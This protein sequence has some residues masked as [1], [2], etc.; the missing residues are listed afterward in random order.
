MGRQAG[1]T[2]LGLS[3]R[4]RRRATKPA[5][6]LTHKSAWDSRE[7]TNA[8][9][10]NEPGRSV[11][12]SGSLAP[13]A[14]DHAAGWHRRAAAGDNSPRQSQLINLAAIVFGGAGA[15]A[16]ATERKHHLHGWRAASRPLLGALFPA[17]VQ[18]SANRSPRRASS[19]QWRPCHTCAA[20]RLNGDATQ[21]SAPTQRVATRNLA[22]ERKRTA[23]SCS[24]EPR[25]WA[26]FV[27]PADC[28]PPGSPF[29]GWRRHD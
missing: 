12:C 28:R 27:A 24:N 22:P 20:R 11:V 1:D 9:G 29:V 2:S 8:A 19:C 15:Q 21:L 6:I 3:R 23:R 16:R 25:K 7:Q 14:G 18:S 5:S 4:R 10:L 26:L 17:V 13:P